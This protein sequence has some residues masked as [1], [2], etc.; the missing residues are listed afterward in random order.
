MK[1]RDNWEDKDI[2]GCLVLRGISETLD[3]AAWTGFIWRK[4]GTSGELL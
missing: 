2:G 4:M 3:E 1:E